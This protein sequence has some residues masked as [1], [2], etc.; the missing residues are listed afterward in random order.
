MDTEM[1]IDISCLI[2]KIG[3]LE[4]RVTVLEDTATAPIPAPKYGS[5]NAD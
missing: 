4:A 3:L 5:K 2:E 1:D